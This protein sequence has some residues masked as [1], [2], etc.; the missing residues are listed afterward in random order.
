[1]LTLNSFGSLGSSAQ[2][3]KRQRERML[4]FRW[5]VWAKKTGRVGAR[6]GKVGLM[7]IS[8]TIRLKHMAWA[9]MTWEVRVRK[10]RRWAGER[11]RLMLKIVVGR[12]TKNYSGV[13][14][15]LWK[16]NV[17]RMVEAERIMEVRVGF[18]RHWSG[19]C[20]GKRCRRLLVRW[21]R[22]SREMGQEEFVCRWGVGLLGRIVER[23][24]V[25]RVRIAFARWERVERVPRMGEKV[26]EKE[27]M[28]SGTTSTIRK[29]QHNLAARSI[30]HMCKNFER[31]VFVHS[32]RIWLDHVRARGLD[33]KLREEY[34][35][36][37]NVME[38]FG[39]LKE[40]QT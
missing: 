23:S 17:G 21:A 38:S 12:M 9:K 30:S 1:M 19:V 22:V 11:R 18:L 6:E 13:G 20:W 32:W 24:L 37:Q 31:R 3:A 10:G 25:S 36:L 39:R 40:H 34:T 7:L 29:V 26:A 14:W 8:R 27:K 33:D 4:R 2:V 28:G 16:M 35:Y 5:G 15:N